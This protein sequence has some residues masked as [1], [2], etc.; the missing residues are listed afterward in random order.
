MAAGSRG[1]LG[2]FETKLAA[3]SLA[4][5][6]GLVR[7]SPPPSW[8]GQDDDEVD[9]HEE[10]ES[11][12]RFVVWDEVWDGVAGEIALVRGVLYPGRWTAL[13]A[14][15]KAGKSDLALHMAVCIARGV[16]P[17]TGADTVPRGVI[18]LDGEMGLDDV[19]RRLKTEVGL[20]AADLARFYYNDTPEVL[21]GGPE[22]RELIERV[23]A[24][25]VAL[26]VFD[27]FNEFVNGDE[28]VAEPW[29]AFFKHV[30]RPLKKHKVA[31][32]TLDNTGKEPGN[33]PRGSSVKVDKAD[34]VF[35]LTRS[36][37]GAT[38]R[39]THTRTRD[40][41]DKLELVRQEHHLRYRL[42]GTAAWSAAAHAIA[43]QLDALKLP[44]S[45]TNDQAR[46]AMKEA[47][48]PYSNDPLAEAVRL[49]KAR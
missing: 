22:T 28:N 39:R 41:A 4:N 20:V 34:I 24:H 6:K 36:A 9:E 29:R 8:Q 17:F 19:L 30:V 16:D 11:R 33:G 1:S 43:L 38:L 37:K 15:A 18:Y 10:E 31:V 47:E 7:L 5:S 44:N 46:R 42:P 45:A 25:D 12:L 2:W 40:A 49:R 14:A 21:S 27:G 35:D 32:L 23:V 26:V 3:M 48:Q 13:A